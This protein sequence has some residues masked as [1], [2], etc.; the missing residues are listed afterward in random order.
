M[1][2]H[3]QRSFC[4]FACPGICSFCTPV[5]SL[6]RSLC[7]TACPAQLAREL[8]SHKEVHFVHPT[9]V[10]TMAMREIK[11]IVPPHKS[12]EVVECFKADC[13]IEI[14]HRTVGDS[15]HTVTM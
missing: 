14:V 6:Q 12:D 4:H 13:G 8:H 3:V 1:T 9:L 15:T 7:T 5:L 11:V 2:Q 10:A